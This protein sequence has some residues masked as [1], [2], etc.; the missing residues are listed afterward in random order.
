MPSFNPDSLPEEDRE[1]ADKDDKW[2]EE[3]G[4]RIWRLRFYSKGVYSINFTF[5]DSNTKTRLATQL[6]YKS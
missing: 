3:D 5:S 4:K 1:L 2:I 6:P